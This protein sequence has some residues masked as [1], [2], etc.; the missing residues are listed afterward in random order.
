M[1]I[2]QKNLPIILI[3]TGGEF[4]GITFPIPFVFG[5]GA[6]IVRPDTWKLKR[7]SRS[8]TTHTAASAFLDDFGPG[9]PT[10]VMAGSTG[11][12]DPAELG[13]LVAIQLLEAFL[14][15]YLNRRK[16]TAEAGGDPDT[17]HLLYLDALNLE[18]F[19]VYVADFQIDRS[20]N[21]PLLYFYTVQFTVLRDLKYEPLF[22]IA[23]VPQ[24]EPLGLLRSVKTN[25]A[26][27][28]GA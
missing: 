14:L 26:E 7:P 24:S 22:G 1:P 4:F 3:L 16:R 23:D 15:E 11:W 13:G 12:S 6:G 28:L 18:A 21:S 8:T 17:V 2:N 27:L 19:L 25:F 10:L 5:T 9:V 20:K